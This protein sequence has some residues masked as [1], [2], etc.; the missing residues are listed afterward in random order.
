MNMIFLSYQVDPFA[1]HRQP[2]IAEREDAYRARRRQMII[3]PDRHDPF[4]D[5]RCR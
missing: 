5:G 1:Q 4:Q 3:S 2:T